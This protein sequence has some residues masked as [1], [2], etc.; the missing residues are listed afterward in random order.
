MKKDNTVNEYLKILFATTVRVVPLSLSP[1]SETV[2]SLS[3]ALSSWGRAREK[4]GR[5]RRG[6]A[7][8][9]ARHFFSLVANYREPGTGLTVNKPRGKMVA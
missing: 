6:R 8:S 7:V 9:L 4:R 1:S 3:Q 2:N 5:L